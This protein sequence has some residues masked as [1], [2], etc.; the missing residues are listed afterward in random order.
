M[1]YF[2]G[3]LLQPIAESSVM[4]SRRNRNE[5]SLCDNCYKTDAVQFCKCCGKRLRVKSNEYDHEFV[6]PEQPVIARV[7]FRGDSKHA[8]RNSTSRRRD[9]CCESR[10]T[11]LKKSKGMINIKQIGSSQ[12][13]YR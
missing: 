7:Y 3:K 2:K 9:V 4:F 12:G 6:K 5:I 11:C 13:I 10:K 1:K 8:S